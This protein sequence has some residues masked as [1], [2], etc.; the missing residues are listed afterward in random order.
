M[1]EEILYRDWENLEPGIDY[2]EDV[3]YSLIS[4]TEP[5]A[6][7]LVEFFKA[8]ELFKDVCGLEI[9]DRGSLDNQFFGDFDEV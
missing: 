3:Y 8:R 5:F 4:L 6:Y 1:F 9:K 2:V 7:V